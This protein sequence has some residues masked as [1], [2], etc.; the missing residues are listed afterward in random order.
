MFRSLVGLT[1]LGL[2]TTLTVGIAQNPPALKVQRTHYPLRTGDANT[3]A[4]VL[5]KHFKGDAE[6]LAAPKGT[7]NSLL[8]TASPET[9]AEILKL[10]GQFDREPR[11]VELEIVTA[12]LASKQSPFEKGSDE[13]EFTGPA[14]E[15]HAKLES[16]T[17]AG[18]LSA[19]KR[20]KLGAISGQVT[21]VDVGGN[22]PFRTGGQVGKGG[23]GSA[24]YSYQPQGTTIS[25]TPRI[26]GKNTI[27][28]ELDLK[29]S[30]TRGGDM[31]GAVGADEPPEFGTTTL[32]T[33]V[34]VPTGNAVV[35][36]AVRT[37]GK[38][39]PTVALVIVTARVTGDK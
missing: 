1:I 36:Q 30:R 18:Q 33:R 38:A 13:M 21:K 28:V 24:T 4:E 3:L 17:K 7:D 20:V 19:V 14:E 8:I 29:E 5:G 25:V 35:A 23:F 9:T 22:K 12:D 27:S 31:G 37:E 34:I 2:F 6:V 26:E 11:M 10:L 16:L 32:S 15:V 39:G